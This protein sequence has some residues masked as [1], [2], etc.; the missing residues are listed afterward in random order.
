MKKIISLFCA[1]V[2][3]LCVFG[4]CT[5]KEANLSQVLDEINSVY[6][7]SGLTKITDTNDLKAYY[8]IEPEDVKQFAAEISENTSAVP[9]EV[10]LVEAVDS[11]A[12]QNIISKLSN[13]YNAIYN[14][15]ASYDT[16]QLDI[17][18]NCTV[19]SDGNYVTLIVGEDAQS[20][21]D[22]FYSYIK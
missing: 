7:V 4:G 12:A 5:T 9:F 22:I 6:N 17:I 19:T 15:Y 8:Q 2:M 1:A 18:K 10:V 3:C 13:R 14:M 20:M 16:N 11:T 21:L